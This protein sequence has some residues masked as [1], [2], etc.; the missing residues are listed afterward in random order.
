VISIYINPIMA[1]LTIILSLPNLI[2]T[3]SFKS[4][5]EKKQDNIISENNSVVSNFQDIVDGISDWKTSSADVNIFKLFKKHTK[6]AELIIY[7]YF[8]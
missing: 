1:L 6:R 7:I 4:S 3:I 2:V 5:L 8:T